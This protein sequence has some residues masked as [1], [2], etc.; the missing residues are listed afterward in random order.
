MTNELAD[1]FQEFVVKSWSSEWRILREEDE[2][3]KGMIERT[4]NGL[5]VFI[6][7]ITTSNSAL[8]MYFMKRSVSKAQAECR[9]FN[10]KT[11]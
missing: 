1:I 7:A 11:F 5:E 10:S 8:R 3:G 6:S 2:I 4:N 9:N